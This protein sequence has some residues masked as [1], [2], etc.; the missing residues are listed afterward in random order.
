MLCKKILP[1]LVFLLSFFRSHAQVNLQ[2][3]SATFSLPMFS[4]E[5]DKSR[6]HSIVALSYNSGSGLKVNEAASNVGQGWNLVTGG[7]IVRLQAGEPDDQVAYGNPSETDIT[8]YPAGILYATVPAANGCPN[9]LTKY[10]IYGWKNQLYAQHNVIAEDKQLDYFSFQFNGKAGM[11][12]LDPEDYTKTAKSLGDTKMKI[13]F[14]EDGNLQS[15][16]DY[17]HG[18]KTGDWKVYDEKGKVTATDPYDDNGNLVPQK[19]P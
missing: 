6:L 11:F 9:A 5:D 16:G 7:E 13:T 1:A 19:T 4:W 15:T 8:K 10:P 14:L 3:G 2:T 17:N 18:F 12:V